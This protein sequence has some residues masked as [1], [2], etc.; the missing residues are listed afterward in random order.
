MATSMPQKPTIVI[1][2]GSFSP[3]SLYSPIIDQLS[4]YGYEAVSIDLPSIGRFQKPHPATMNEDAA[5]IQSVITTI[6]DQ[7]KD[8]ML[9]MHS[10]GGIPGTESTK[11]LSKVERQASGK[12]GGITRLFYMSAMILPVG[13]SLTDMTGP[14]PDHV[15]VKVSHP[16]HPPSTLDKLTILGSLHVY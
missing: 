3:A 10:Y 13:L 14:L 4:N 11:G 7:G 12:R 15:I 2:P 5:H 6:A 9:V 16:I 8:V 1:I